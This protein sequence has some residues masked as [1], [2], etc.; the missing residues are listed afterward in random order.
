MTSNKT[1]QLMGTVQ[2][3][4]SDHWRLAAGY[5]HVSVDFDKNNFHADLALSGPIF[6]AS[7]RF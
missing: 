2:Y 6:G 7:Y 5:R 1:W 4:I 3:D